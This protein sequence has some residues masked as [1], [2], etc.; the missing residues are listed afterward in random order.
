MRGFRLVICNYIDYKHQLVKYLSRKLQAVIN[1]DFDVIL[2]RQFEKEWDQRKLFRGRD[3][4]YKYLT[5]C[6]IRTDRGRIYYRDVCQYMRAYFIDREGEYI[7]KEPKEF[8]LPTYKPKK[9]KKKKSDPKGPD[10]KYGYSNYG[11][12]NNELFLGLRKEED[13]K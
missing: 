12:V 9:K 13:K 7:F 1:R 3:S 8:V 4:A 10:P 2:A 6:Y 11:R 5:N